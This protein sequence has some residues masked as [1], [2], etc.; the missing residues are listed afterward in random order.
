MCEL[1]NATYRIKP[2]MHSQPETA[3]LL[4]VF[5]TLTSAQPNL[6]SSTPAEHAPAASISLA[7]VCSPTFA[8][9]SREL[10]LGPQIANQAHEQIPEQPSVDR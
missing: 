8:A 1:Q 7:P 4:V 3:G 9:S 6:V 2:Y 10:L 5:M